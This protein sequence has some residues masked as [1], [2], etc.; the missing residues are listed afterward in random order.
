M[1][2]NILLVDDDRDFRAELKEGLEG[3]PV[4]EAAC[5]EEA[6]SILKKPNEIDLVI[7]DV[8]MP[9]I[10][11]TNIL[12]VIKEKYPKT[13]TFILTGFSSKDVAIDALKN[14][15]DD[16]FEKPV[17][18]EIIRSAV[19]RCLGSVKKSDQQKGIDQKIER[20]KEYVKRN[21]SRPVTLAM[22]AKLVGSS[23]K[24]FSRVFKEKNR[25]GFCNFRTFLRLTQAKE[26]LLGTQFNIAQISEKLGFENPESFIRLFK[27]KLKVTPKAFRGKHKGH[28]HPH[29]A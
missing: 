22:A 19:E 2:S 9:G 24:Y 10:I 13:V 6:L 7:L 8:M 5:G 15:A 28:S 4:V 20:I 23:P 1:T 16:Y 27:K 17:N 26:L 18:M 3:Y 29:Q 14:K 12:K 25:M 21:I 11:G